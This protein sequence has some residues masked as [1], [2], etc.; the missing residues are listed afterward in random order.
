MKVVSK[1]QKGISLLEIL[2]VVSIF[3]VLGVVTTR[4]VLL[5]LQGSKKSEAIVRVRENLNYSLGI[6]ERQI[7]NADKIDECP[8][9]SPNLVSLTDQEGVTTTFSCVNVGSADGYIASASARLTNDT[10]NVT[11]CS[12]TCSSGSSVNPPAITVSIVASDKSLTGVQGS[13]VSV[14]TQIHLRNY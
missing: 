6:I 5:T 7:R 14:T 1:T 2:V 13:E 12:F 4:A 11:A 9:A 3:A 8:N 10:I